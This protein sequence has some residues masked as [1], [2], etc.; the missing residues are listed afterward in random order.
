MEPAMNYRVYD[1]NVQFWVLKTCS[2]V[3]FW[4]S[5]K[6]LHNMSLNVMNT[7]RAVHDV[8]HQGS[9]KEYIVSVYQQGIFKN[10]LNF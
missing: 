5:Q 4:L 7:G 3:L 2:A 8:K 10:F 9:W 1:I 6:P